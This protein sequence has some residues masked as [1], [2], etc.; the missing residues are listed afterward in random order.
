MEE[1]RQYKGAVFFDVDGTLVD[2]RKKIYKPTEATKSAIEK[3][4]KNGWLVGIA[5]GRS[6]CYIPDTGIDFNCYVSCN[7]AVAE[8]EDKVIFNDCIKAE[9]ILRLA[10]YFGK[11]RIAYDIE[12]RDVCY[13]DE[14]REDL[15]RAIMEVFHIDGAAF[16]PYRSG[17]AFAANKMMIAFDRGEQFEEIKS[18]LSGEYQV[19]RHHKNNSADIMRIGMS[20]AVGIKAVIKFAGIDIA[21]TYAF[22][23]D[24]ND[25]EM[26]AA[27][28]CGI[29]MTPHSASLE[30]TAKMFTGGVDEEGISSA[31]T[32][33]GLI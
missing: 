16:V 10:G 13:Y 14:N 24:V 25:I 29:A 21:D 7:G 17:S 20:K 28:G 31:L 22:G 26:L 11:N 19:I 9:E 30:K 15:L 2:E 12:T 23:D 3:L 27:V 1:K 33:L 6:K 32:K 18:D 5:T 8:I 4:R